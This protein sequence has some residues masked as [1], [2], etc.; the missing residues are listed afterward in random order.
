MTYSW[1]VKDPSDVLDYGIDWS[2]ALDAND[3]IA[4]SSFSITPSGLTAGTEAKTL[5]AT[6]I[7]LSGGTAG[8]VYSV[9]N[10]ITTVLGRTMQRT[11]SLTVSN[12]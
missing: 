4:T 11:V 12:L 9:V 7:F 3:T 8:Q 5:T 10:T 2:T 6:S 1:P